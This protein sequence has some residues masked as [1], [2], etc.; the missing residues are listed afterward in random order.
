[1]AARWHFS[2]SGKRMSRIVNTSSLSNLVD[3]T[4]WTDDFIPAKTAQG[5]MSNFPP[6]FKLPSPFSLP[7]QLPTSPS[8]SW[9]L[10]RDARNLGKW[11]SPHARAIAE[12]LLPAWILD[13][14]AHHENK[15]CEDG[16]TEYILYNLPSPDT[17]SSVI[18]VFYAR[19]TTGQGSC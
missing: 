15:I 8:T 13:M 5:F 1:M 19:G 2:Q 3:A 9:Q 14:G 7:E 12:P 17:V 10:K 6:F 18:H 4:E 16:I 11:Q